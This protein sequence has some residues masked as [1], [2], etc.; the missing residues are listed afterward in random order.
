[1]T[2]YGLRYL[3]AFAVGSVA[4]TLN[5]LYQKPSQL[6]FEANPPWSCTLTLGTANVYGWSILVLTA[7]FDL[8][9]RI[10]L[11][12]AATVLAIGP[13][14]AALECVMGKV[15]MAYFG[16]PQRWKY[17]EWYCPACDGYISLVSTLYFAAIGAAYFFFLYRPLISKI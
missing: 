13:I 14:L 12:T 3:T 9:R 7:Y 10:R 5:E 17:P 15:S 11:P 16:P 8:A 2:S 6:C 1:M 4:G